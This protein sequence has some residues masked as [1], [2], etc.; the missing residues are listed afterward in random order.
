MS[1]TDGLG[2]SVS[3]GIELT[4]MVTDVDVSQHLEVGRLV[5]K[6]KLNPSFT[7]ELRTTGKVTVAGKA[8]CKLRPEWQNA[9]RVRSPGLLH[10]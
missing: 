4:T 10:G 1:C 8:T 6:P 2:H 7:A 9:Q 3:A 5:P